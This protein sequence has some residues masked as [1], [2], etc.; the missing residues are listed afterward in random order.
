MTQKMTKQKM[1]APP[2]KYQTEADGSTTVTRR[3]KEIAAMIDTE[4]PVHLPSAKPFGQISKKFPLNLLK[5]CA[6]NQSP[7]VPENQFPGSQAKP[8]NNNLVTPAIK[9]VL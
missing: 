3:V 5:I 2:S 1:T 6:A 9:F 7:D 4:Q 8:T